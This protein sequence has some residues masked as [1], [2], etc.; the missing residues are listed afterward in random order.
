MGAGTIQA[1]GSSRRRR[2]KRVRPMSEINV[3]PFVD[4]MLVL[5]IIFMV[6][7]PMLTVGVAVNE[8]ETNATAL[9]SQTED[10][11]P[12][13]LYITLEGKFFIQTETDEPVLREELIP[14]LSAILEQR[15][16]KTIWIR[17]DKDLTY[18]PIARLHA[19]LAANGFYQFKYVHNPDS[20][21]INSVKE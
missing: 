2:T 14:K 1:Q 15:K 19:D 8:P 3:T 13:T 6:T 20:S 17:A 7:A 10:E 21:E 9:E 4:V 5:L 12:L 18:A 11:T 16:D